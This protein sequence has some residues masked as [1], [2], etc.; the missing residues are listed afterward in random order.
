[1]RFVAALFCMTACDRVFDLSDP[2]FEPPPPSPDASRDATLDAPPDAPPDAIDPSVDSDLDGIPDIMDNCPMTGGPEQEDADGDGVGDLCDPRQGPADVLYH[3]ETFR[4]DDSRWK[5][6]PADGWERLDGALISPPGGLLAF[7]SAL[8]LDRPVLQVRFE[9]VDF[10]V[11]DDRNNQIALELEDGD[12]A[13]CQAREDVANELPAPISNLLMH[14]H[15][16]TD[17]LIKVLTPEL[18]IATPYLLEYARGTTSTCRISGYMEATQAD[19]PSDQLTTKPKV[20][21]ILATAR[22]R[23]IAIYQARP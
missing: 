7:D 5:R 21:L 17:P 22:I 3:Y 20:S 23:Y 19:A 13:D 6:M 14:T 8:S 9:F 4:S 12:T 1:M 11:R 10:G 18:A 16:V 2:P 15:G